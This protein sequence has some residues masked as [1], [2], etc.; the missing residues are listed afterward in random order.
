MFYYNFSRIF[1]EDKIL[2]KILRIVFINFDK[3]Y[4]RN[5]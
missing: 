2:V 4:S 1:F 5:I 3:I